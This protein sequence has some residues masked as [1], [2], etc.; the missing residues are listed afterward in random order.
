MKRLIPA[1][2]ALMLVLAVGSNPATAKVTP[3]PVVEVCPGH[4]Q[5]RDVPTFPMLPAAE[6][7]DRNDNDLVCARDIVLNN[8]KFQMKTVFIDDFLTD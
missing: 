4:F 8:P 2:V 6:R 3:F 5:L 7:A 1:T